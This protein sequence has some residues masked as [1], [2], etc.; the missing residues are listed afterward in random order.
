[1]ADSFARPEPPYV[2]IVTEI[3]RRIASGELRAG[4]RVPSTRQITQNWGVAMA[5]ATKVLSTLRQEGLVQAMPGV[6]TVVAE[7]EPPAAPRP[8]RHRE[9][10]EPE[11][12]LTQERIVR[13]AI[14]IA[15]AE[16][17][18]ALSMRRV[19][20]QLGVATMSLYRHVRNKEELV[21][22]MADAA[23][24]E[25][26][27]PV[28]PP[29]GWRARL[30]IAARLQWSLYRRHPWLAQAI[31]VTRPQPLPH[32]IAHTEWAL[33]AVDGLGLDPGTVRYVHITMFNYV[34]GIAVNL[35]PEVESA[36]DPGT[37]ADQWLAI[38]GAAA[39]G[40]FGFDLE[41]LFEFGLQRM[42]DGLEVHFTRV[43]EGRVEAR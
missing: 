27:L 13:V 5:T 16:G 20:T 29:E 34:R 33:R 30:E 3:R 24:S 35:T 23:I 40:Y 43:R 2:R 1:M 38:D 42:L 15:D 8:I 9:P 22:Q 26:E 6:G 28:R 36:S 17:P 12:E 21:Q 7:P 31:S 4:D 37:T 10:P 32:L 25:E 11:R 39:R 41:T 18:N 19:A 14:E